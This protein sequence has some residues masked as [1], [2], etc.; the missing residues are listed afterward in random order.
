MKIPSKQELKQIAYNHSSDTD[1]KDFVNL[2]KK[3][4]VKPYYFLIID[5]TLVSDNPLSFRKNLSERI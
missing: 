1:F 4:T 5:N 2:Y 3:F